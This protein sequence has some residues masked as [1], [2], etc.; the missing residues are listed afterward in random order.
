MR[1]CSYYQAQVLRE[2]TWFVVA[3]LRS[4]EHVAFDRTLD[5]QKSIFEFFVPEDQEILFLAIIQD[6]AQLGLVGQLIKLPNRFCE[7]V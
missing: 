4:Y 5:V 1:L 3:V 6:F 7:R 2:K